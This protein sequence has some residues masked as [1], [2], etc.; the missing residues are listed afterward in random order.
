MCVC[1]CSCLCVCNCVYVYVCVTVSVI[2]FMCVCVTVCVCVSL[3]LKLFL[4]GRLPPGKRPSGALAL[5]LTPATYLCSV[6]GWH[7]P[8]CAAEALYE[9][10]LLPLLVPHLLWVKAWV[11]TCC[12]DSLG[13]DWAARQST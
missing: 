2:V 3:G 1:V 9:A 12:Q 11:G 7:C 5:P 6:V 4:S 13:L 8:L 10:A